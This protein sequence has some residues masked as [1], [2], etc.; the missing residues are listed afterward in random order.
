MTYKP[1]I[2]QTLKEC[3]KTIKNTADYLEEMADCEAE[4][5]RASNLQWA[6]QTLEKLYKEMG[7]V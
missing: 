4:E 7:E 6:T 3:L 5:I 2:R 1:T